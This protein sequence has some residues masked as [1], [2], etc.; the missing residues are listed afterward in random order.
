MVLTDNA[1]F[2]NDIKLAAVSSTN[3]NTKLTA[4]R[5]KYEKEF[6]QKLLGYELASLILAYDSETSTQRIKDIVEGKEYTIDYNNRSQKIKWNG[7]INIDLV[8][9]IAYYVYCMF[10]A[11]EERE[12]TPT[13]QFFATVENSVRADITFSF[14]NAYGRMKELAGYA[15][16]SELEPSLYNFLLTEEENNT[17]PELIFT[18]FPPVSNWLL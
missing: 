17:Y 18:E 13:G 6:L 15:G 5:I 10:I 11:F 16:Q 1:Y 3:L 9:P 12:S 14:I 2:V 8:S 4:Y 7:L